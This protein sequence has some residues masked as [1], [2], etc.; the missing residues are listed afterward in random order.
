ME[1]PMNTN[2]ERLARIEAIVERLDHEL[3]GNGQPGFI[4]KTNE[5][6]SSIEGDRSWLKGAY[7]VLSALVSALGLGGVI[8][9][10]GNRNH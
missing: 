7:W 5:R 1:L 6:L 2:S 10:F 9:I 8:H 4:T 3:C